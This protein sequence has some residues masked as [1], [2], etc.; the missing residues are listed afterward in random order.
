[1]PLVAST[2]HAIGPIN[3]LV[4]QAGSLGSLAGPPVLALWVGWSDWSLAPVL[5]LVVAA[6]GAAAALAVRRA[7]P[8]P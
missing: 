2:P 1:V 7:S 8:P 6:M 3:G 5:L 4:A